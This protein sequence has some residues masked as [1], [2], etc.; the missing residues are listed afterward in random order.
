M[1]LR[2]DLLRVGTYYPPGQPPVTFTEADIRQIAQN[3]T[4]MLAAGWAMP[5]GWEHHKHLVPQKRLVPMSSADAAASRAK[6]FIAPVTQVELWPNG[7]GVSVVADVPDDEA[8]AVQRV[9]FVSPGLQRDWRTGDGKKYPGWSVVHVA[10]TPQPVAKDQ[11]RFVPLSL[12]SGMLCLSL[13]DLREGDMDLDDELEN[14]LDDGGDTSPESTP[15]PEAEP[16]PEPELPEPPPE[17]MRVRE[18]VDLAAQCGFLLGDDTTD[19]TFLDRFIVAAKTYLAAQGELMNEMP[20]S[21]A[22]L[23]AGGAPAD[24]TP[25][26]AGTGGVVMSMS[27]LQSKLVEHERRALA[28]R[29]SKLQRT[30]RIPPAVARQLTT[31]L[32]SVNLSLT[33]EAALTPNTLLGKIEA[34]EALPAKNAGGFNGKSRVDLSHAKPVPAEREATGEPPRTPAEVSKVVDDFFQT[35][36][37]VT[38]NKP[39]AK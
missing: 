20:D 4:S 17:T 32:N 28:V 37:Q 5:M 38:V 25:A 12:P 21:N 39:A 7:Q 34:Y 19:S 6:H 1:R 22:G 8:P 15:E 26:P 3:G 13:N 35:G 10:V 16:E 31:E 18:A 27:A 23:Q 33:P 14:D 2:K 11:G 36:R 9:G 30:E 29:I 24:A